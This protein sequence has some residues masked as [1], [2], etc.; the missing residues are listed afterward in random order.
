MVANSPG[1]SE[2]VWDVVVLGLGF[3]ALVERH[4]EDFAAVQRVITTCAHVRLVPIRFRQTL[5][6]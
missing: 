6:V 1:G 5:D 3:G 4:L 2:T